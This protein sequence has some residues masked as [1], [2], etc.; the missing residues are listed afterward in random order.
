MILSLIG[1]NFINYVV[2]VGILHACLFMVTT[3]EVSNFQK[4]PFV[5]A[6]AV[7]SAQSVIRPMH[8]FCL[9]SFL[10]H[11]SVCVTSIRSVLILNP[12]SR[13]LLSVRLIL[14]LM[15]TMSN[16]SCVITGTAGRRCCVP[17]RSAC[18]LY[19]TWSLPAF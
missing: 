10:I 18:H 3:S 4:E 19:Q 14:R 1:F 7:L 15:R 13:L 16:P 8:F 6:S 2:L 12:T 11:R 5:C 9:P 17:K